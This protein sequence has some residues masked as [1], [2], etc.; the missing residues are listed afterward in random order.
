MTSYVLVPILDQEYILPEENLTLRLRV[1]DNILSEMA[2]GDL[3]LSQEL[4]WAN[5]ALK[6]LWKKLAHII[7]IKHKK[8]EEDRQQD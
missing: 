6:E 3:I 2:G 4:V 5:T 8:E 1:A 7:N